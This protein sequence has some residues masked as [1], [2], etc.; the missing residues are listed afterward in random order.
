MNAAYLLKDKG[1]NKVVAAATH[2]DFVGGADKILQDSPLDAIWVT[3]TID[4]PVGKV[5]PKLTITSISSLIASEIRK[6]L[7]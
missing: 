5:F 1:A 4:I 2:A 7:K 3:D 6:M